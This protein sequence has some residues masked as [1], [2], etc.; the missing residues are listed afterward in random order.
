MIDTS[1]YFADAPDYTAWAGNSGPAQRILDCSDN[2]VM[3][4]FRAR[5]NRAVAE[6]HERTGDLDFA[7]V[8]Y[9]P[10]S[11]ATDVE[12]D[13]YDEIHGEEQ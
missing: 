4:E 8:N 10:T 7:L 5:C 12:G 1:D 13:Y 9:D 3:V 2:D 11:I 6:L